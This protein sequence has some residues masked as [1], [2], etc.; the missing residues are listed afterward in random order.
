MP[1]LWSTTSARLSNRTN[2]TRQTDM[3]PQRGTPM[4]CRGE[5]RSRVRGGWSNARWMLTTLM[6][7]CWPPR[8]GW[9]HI[10]YDKSWRDGAS[11][12]LGDGQESVQ[13]QTHVRVGGGT[14]VFEGGLFPRF[15]LFWKDWRSQDRLVLHFSFD[16][17]ALALG[18]YGREWPNGISASPTRCIIRGRL[19]ELPFCVL[20]PENRRVVLLTW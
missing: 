4:L 7:C 5:H 14:N 15:I 17:E 6:P 12:S 10:S 2:S 19:V 16:H 18:C 11:H 3:R 9:V 1:G 20:S 13:M 8:L